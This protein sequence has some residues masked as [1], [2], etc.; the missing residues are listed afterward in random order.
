MPVDEDGMKILVGRSGVH[1]GT[2][3]AHGC[4]VRDCTIRRVRPI[5]VAAARMQDIQLLVIR[6]NKQPAIVD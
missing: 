6:A 4:G 2:V 3:R 1:G 5:H